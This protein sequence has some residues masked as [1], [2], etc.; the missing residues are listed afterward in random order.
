MT[1]S[2]MIER[3]NKIAAFLQGRADMAIGD[4]KMVL[5]GWWKGADEAAALLT[6]TKPRVLGWEELVSHDGAIWV[7]YNPEMVSLPD[8]WAFL[9]FISDIGVAQLAVWHVGQVHYRIDSYGKTWRCWNV[10][11]TDEEREAAAWQ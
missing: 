6:R 10:K 5:T 2:E 7:E 4:A 8:K 9:D 1:R 3:L 11:P